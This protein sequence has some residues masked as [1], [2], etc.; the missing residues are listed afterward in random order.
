MNPDFLPY[1]NLL[2]RAREMALVNSAA[3][4][5]SWD[6]ETCMPPKALPYRAEQMAHFSGWTHR[7]FTDPV[8]GDWISECEQQGF[9]PHSGEAANLREWR[10]AYDRQTRLPVA[11]VEE[12]QRQCTLARDA[13][14]EA[15]RQSQFVIFRP[16]LEQILEMCRQMA[17]HWG[18]ERSPYEALLE[19]YE[20]ATPLDELKTCFNELR[21]TLV[22]LIQQGTERARS[23][24]DDLLLGDYPIERQ[25]AFNL[26]VAEAMGF[27]LKAGRIDTTT[28]PFCNGINPGD[29]RLTT[30]YNESD[31]TQ[32]L[33]GVMHEAGHGLYEQG[34]P[35]EHFG[36]P[37]GSS[38]SLGIH[39]SQSRLWENHVGRSTAFW[40]QWHPIACR[41][42]PSL[43]KLSP[44]Q[45]TQAIN[46]VRP[47]FIRVEADQVTYD[48]HIILRF[49]LEQALLEKEL[50]VA[51]L[52]S[53]WNAEFKKMLDLQVA[54][55][56]Q[57]CLQDIHWSLGAFG[58]FPTYTLGNLNAAQLIHF[59]RRDNPFLAEGLLAG[60]YS[61]LL[62]WLREKIHRQGK[63]Y[64]ARDLMIKTTGLPTQV[65]FHMAHLQETLDLNA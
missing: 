20:P 5:L 63:R 44:D 62:D 7:L 39:E 37:L 2:N 18:Y 17:Y 65:Q 23:T 3:Q 31:F 46:R 6:Q 11:L 26:E 55:D 53:A 54:Q 38:V 25:Q 8:V 52:P 12:F 13:W 27:D 10:R 16:H 57:G 43:K 9:P 58:Y 29:C 48:L 40:R 34:L 28:H 49:E 61:F 1:K 33:Y 35:A 60:D 4:L 32:S 15:R 42:F 56:N 64:T 24:P 30:R 22:Q 59:A 14:V 41:Y 36:T 19:E 21:P 50:P 51:E 45:I 47:S